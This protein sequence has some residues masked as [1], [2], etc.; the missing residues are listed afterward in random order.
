[1]LKTKKEKIR[2][3]DVFNLTF[4]RKGFI[5]SKGLTIWYQRK[6][7]LDSKCNHLSNIINTLINWYNVNDLGVVNEIRKLFFKIFPEQKNDKIPVL[8]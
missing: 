5:S 3:S 7:D 2:K 1:M 6:N 4:V 8:A